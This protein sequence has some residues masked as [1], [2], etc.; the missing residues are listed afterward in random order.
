MGNSTNVIHET[1]VVHPDAD[2]GKRNYIG[3]HAVIGATVSIGDDNWIGPS[4]VVGSPSQHVAHPVQLDEW[5]NGVSFP[6]DVIIGSRNVLREFV[7]IQRPTVD[8]N[9]S[10]GDDNYF[11]T[12]VHIPHDAHIGDHVTLANSVQI[13]GHTQVMSHTTIGLGTVVHQRTVIGPFAM[14]GMGAA[15]KGFCYPIATYVGNPARF[16]GPNRIDRFARTLTD[17]NSERISS[18]L[19]EAKNEQKLWSEIL[20][21]LNEDPKSFGA[22]SA[23]I[24][25]FEELLRTK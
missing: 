21:L 1:A 12:Q 19:S 22:M 25:Q 18:R 9:T 3:P 14:V 7:T 23:E 2:L 17:L 10:I 24:E 5:T 6:A 13:G 4:V 16:L 8:K 20:S 15:L 11:M